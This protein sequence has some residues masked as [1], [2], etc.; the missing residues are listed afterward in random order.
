MK[1]VG[2][3]WC[4][5]ALRK[6]VVGREFGVGTVR[7]VYIESTP[8]LKNITKRENRRHSLRDSTRGPRQAKGQ[9]LYGCYSETAETR[10]SF[11]VREKKITCLPQRMICHLY[12]TLRN[13]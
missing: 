2:K 1:Q 13:T 5:K 10:S 4:R 12:L 11:D 6:K 8:G 9:R 3:R 7:V